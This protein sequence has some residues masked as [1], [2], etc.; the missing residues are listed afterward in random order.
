MPT[1]LLTIGPVHTMVQN[2]EYATPY[3]LC[4]MFAQP[5]TNIEVSNDKVTWAAPTTFNIASAFMRDTVGGALVRF[6]PL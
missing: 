6:S 3:R 1:E 2:R 4:T 5:V